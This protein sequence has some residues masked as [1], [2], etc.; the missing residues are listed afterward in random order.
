L[1]DLHP[2]PPSPL[3]WIMAIAKHGAVTTYIRITR[4]LLTFDVAEFDNTIIS[5]DSLLPGSI[6]DWEMI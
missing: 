1:L 5:Q 2:Q 3:A 4:H 6:F